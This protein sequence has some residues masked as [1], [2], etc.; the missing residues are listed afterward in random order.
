MGIF[1]SI[2][3]IILYRCGY[4]KFMTNDSNINALI[5]LGVGCYNSNGLGS[6][7]KLG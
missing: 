4:T 1:V 2:I 5:N 6:K 3:Y 7:S